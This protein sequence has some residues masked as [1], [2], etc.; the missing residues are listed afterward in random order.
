MGSPGRGAPHD[1][2]K[3]GFD[4][5]FD[6][7]QLM[8][9]DSSISAAVKLPPREPRTVMRAFRDHGR[10]NVAQAQDSWQSDAAWRSRNQSAMLIW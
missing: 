7:R 3:D 9:N 6:C 8:R 5:G 4:I 1:Q 2:R 10:A